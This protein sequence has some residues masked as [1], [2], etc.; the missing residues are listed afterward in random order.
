VAPEPIEEALLAAIPGAKQVVLAGHGRSFLAAIVTGE[1]LPEQVKAALESL[2]QQL[3][4]YKRVR[5]FVIQVEPFSIENG[6]LTAN[7]K[8]KR[9][10]IASRLHEAIETL[11]NRSA[12]FA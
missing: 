8:L 3:P 9:D 2:N 4:H 12:K 5:D 1:V 10:A 6:L 7:G 11:Y